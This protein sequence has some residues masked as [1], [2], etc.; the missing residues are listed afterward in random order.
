MK[1]LAMKRMMS[2]MM[3]KWPCLSRTLEEYL[4][5]ATS[6]IMARTR[7][8]MNQEEDPTSLALG[9]RNKGGLSGREEKEQR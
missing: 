1:N 3:S 6:G 9:A 4:E 8:N 5:R 2:L 7:A